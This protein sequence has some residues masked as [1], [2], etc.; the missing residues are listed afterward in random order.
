MPKD[1][2]EPVS[3]AVRPLKDSS[4]LL[5]VGWV[6]LTTT[7]IARL[8]TLNVATFDG[9][10]F[11]F[12]MVARDMLRGKLPY[13]GVFDN[14]PVGLT[15]LFGF[16]EWVG[17][18]SIIAI[19]V[20]GLLSAVATSAIIYATARQL[21]LTRAA[22]TSVVAVSSCAFL[23]FGGWASMSELVAAPFLGF[24]NLILLRSDG[25]QWRDSMGIGCAFGL[26]CQATYLVAPVMVLSTIGIVIA[27]S[28]GLTERIKQVVWI[29][30]AFAAV[31]LIVW[32]PHMLTGVWL[33]YVRDQ[34][35]YHSR[36]RVPFPA[37]KDWLKWFALPLAGLSVP[38]LAASCSYGRSRPPPSSFW[39]LALGLLGSVI[40]AAA[41]N[42]FYSH[43]FI[44]A[45]PNAAVLTAMLWPTESAPTSR[46]STVAL[47]AGGALMVVSLAPY[48]VE[49]LQEP[50]IEGKTE[51]LVD[52]LVGK[53]HAIFVFNETPVLYYVS[54][55]DAVGR[56]IFPSHYISGC[57]GT[58]PMAQP[59]TVLDD[60][61]NTR[62]ELVLLGSQCD[63][64]F[65]ADAVVRR[66]GYRLVGKAFDRD[67][68]VDAYMLRTPPGRRLVQ[69]GSNS[70]FSASSVSI[71][72]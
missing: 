52:Q 33:T 64:D 40:A 71:H 56:W 39:P 28:G 3:G 48:L 54:R 4:R 41:S 31:T 70:R 58:A 30:T 9:D 22:A 57:D 20:V 63:L 69:V 34:L 7:I 16:A 59:A 68:E 36:Y 42:R 11:A 24:G 32:L 61:L 23:V 67:R 49:R 60:G 25:R 65:D 5:I 29:A 19:H 12:A 44:L 37:L 38:I 6:L 47:L 21:C 72:P 18:K 45:I 2:S 66:A 13:S 14:K 43:Y 51:N 15:Y 1:S 10:E 62:P 55:S 50:G 35:L 17:D 26:A 53:G 8:I 46:Q 27:G